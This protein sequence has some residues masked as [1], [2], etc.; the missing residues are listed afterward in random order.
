MLVG[1]AKGFRFGEV[2]T[3][4]SELIWEGTVRGW[5]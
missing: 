1:G 2:S 4:C 3:P 5:G